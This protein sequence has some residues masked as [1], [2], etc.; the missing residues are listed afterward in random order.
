ME[1]FILS[2]IPPFGSDEDDADFTKRSGR[3]RKLESMVKWN[4][5][6]ILI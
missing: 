5:C 4:D 6:K 2:R 3:N 1:H